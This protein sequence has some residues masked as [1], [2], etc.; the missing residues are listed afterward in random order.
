MRFADQVHNSTYSSAAVDGGTGITLTTVNMRN[1][2]QTQQ[3]EISGGAAMKFAVGF[4]TGATNTFS[5]QGDG[6]PDWWKIK[7]GLNPYSTDP[8]N[9]PNGDPDGDGKSNLTEYL[10]GTNP[11]VAG[12]DGQPEPKRVMPRAGSPSR[13]RA[14]A[15][16]ST[17][18]NT[19]T[20]LAPRFR[21]PAPTCSGT[22]G[23][24]DLHRTTVHSPAAPLPARRNG[25]TVC[26]SACRR[27]R[28]LVFVAMLPRMSAPSRFASARLAVGCCLG[29]AA[30]LLFFQP[31]GQARPGAK[32]LVPITRATAAT[33]TA[34]HIPDD[35]TDLN[36]THMRNPEFEFD[37]TTAVT[38]YTGLQKYNNPY[39]TANQT[40]GTLYVKKSSATA[41]TAVALG[42]DSG[43][44]NNQYWKAAYTFSAA[45]GYGADDVIQYYFA[46]TFDTS[47]GAASLATTFVYGGNGDAGGSIATG[48]TATESVAQ[49]KPFSLR[50]RPAF[51]YHGNNRVITGNSVQF[52]TEAGY[53]GKD[54]TAASQWINQGTLY[55]TTDGT[56]PAGAL[57]AAANSSTTAVALAFD[58]TGNNNSIAGNSMYWVGT[59]NNLPTYTTINYKI[60]LR[61]TSNNEE[62]FAD[63][64]SGNS[65]TVFSFSNGTVGDPTLTVNGVSA[66][67][68]TTHLFVNEISGDQIPLTVFFNPAAPN[69]DASTVQVYTNL[70][71]RD[72]ASLS[73]TDSFG[74]A[75]EEGIQPPSGNMVD[76]SDTHYYKA[77]T[78][79]AISGGYQVVL[80][81]TKTGAYRLT[82]RYKLVGGTNWIYYTTSG[83]RDHAIVVSPTQARGIQLY[84]LNT[85]N[86]DATGDQPAQRSTFPDLSD[87]TKRWNLTYLKNLGCNWLWFQPIHPNGIDGR[88]TNPD[89]NAAYT[90]GSP[91]AVKNFFEIMPLMGKSFT[92][93]AIPSA[94]DPSPVAPTDPSYATS[95]RGL[96][97]KD[98]AN[99]VAAA[100]AAVV[101]V[102]LDAPF[103]HTSFDAELGLNG[104]SL[105]APASTATYISEIRNTE[106][107]FFSLSGNY[108]ARASSAATVAL[109]PDRGDF[110]KFT[111]VHDI[112]FGTYS[113]LVDVNDADDGNYLN[114]GDQFFGYLGSSA[115]PNG[116]PYWNSVDFTSGSAGNNITRNV[117]HYFGQYVPYWLSQTGHVDSNGNLV[118]NSTNTDVNQRLIED[119]RGIDGLRADFGQGLPPQCWEYIINVARSYK[120]N[121]VF[122]TESL[123]GG[124]VT[125][126]SNRHFDILNESIVF[127]F[128]SATTAQNYRDIF[129]G[130]RSTYGQSLILMNST[131][132]D[133]E[134]YADPFQALIRYMV[135]GSIDGVPM[136][137]YGQ[138]NGISQNFG[139]DHYEENF[140]KEIPHFKEY[141]SLGPIL[142]NQ[143]YALQQLYPDFAAV[144]QARQFSPALRSSNRYYLNQTDGSVQQNIFSV[145]KYDTANA[146][147]GVADVVFALVNLDRNNNQVGNYNVNV[148][149]DGT[150]NVFGIHSGRTYNVKNIAA[151]LGTDGTRRNQFL[152]SGGVS[153]A[154]LLANGLYASLNPVP[155]ADG[156]WATAPF[157]AQYL[158]L[159]DVTPPPTDTAPA[160]AKAYALG[161]SATFNWP[162]VTDVLGG[163]SGYRLIVSTDAAGNNVV[164]NGLVGN[165]TAYTINGVVPG[166]TLYARVDAVNNAGV[167]GP[168][169]ATSVGTPVLDPAADADGDGMTNAAEDAAGTNPLDAGSNFRV[170]SVVRS[171]VNAS[172][173]ITWSSVAGKRYQVEST[174]NLASGTYT[175]VSAVLTATA[176]STSFTDQPTGTML[177]YRVRIIQ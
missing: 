26:R 171:A 105:F 21:R 60:G 126:R 143:T 42:Y 54:G 123:D 77:Y 34:W 24:M 39:G 112:Y 17:R 98:F 53:I 97:K 28:D 65:G 90:V 74:I 99:F 72:Y 83:R 76:T 166:Q 84:E 153:G 7:Y 121:F 48:T 109:A 70:N 111:D 51:V 12:H 110:G 139:F 52:T 82:A 172:V 23:T 132:H 36:G 173:Q 40:G 46:L 8:V 142:G 31:I 162:A 66:N 87:S 133:E 144:G 9:G 124:A 174:T 88:Q 78:M 101:G 4:Q 127:S 168:L 85:L 44:G 154:N 2:A 33:A 50:D 102:M 170:Q 130:R 134:T 95:P 141:N 120:W 15:T 86:V 62:K 155:T 94:N 135:S 5:T 116:D 81:A 64:N 16:A 18:C 67:Y 43:N 113:A 103:N 165:V 29:V 122:M 13:S 3:V 148:S 69:V 177:F 63:Y 163:I 128:Q 25:F 152:I 61:N 89:T 150:N 115:Y 47:G 93:S 160:P 11:T 6:I 176:G 58:H 167:E 137:F 108:A 32:A 10:L 119:S 175:A 140:G 129:D 79:P 106:A 56:A 146:S 161:N 20:L 14:C 41:W 159:Y 157:E 125:Y 35:S 138:E 104:T 151:Y 27:P 136:V 73:Y 38:F 114:E 37:Q 96:A 92:G 107:R 169:S 68:T 118:G 147:P 131:S 22:G 100:D 1:Q 57:G 158:K 145:G 164:F 30:G 80:N 149:V 75:T 156:A 19:P 55:Y 91:Y 59:V 49:A 45:N 117:W 71:R